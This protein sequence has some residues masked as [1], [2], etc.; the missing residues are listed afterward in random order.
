MSD[1][2]I[3]IRQSRRIEGIL[4]KQFGAI[5]KGLHVKLSSIESQVPQHIVKTTRWIATM[6]NSVVH[7]DGFEINNIDSF[8]DACERVIN[9]LDEHSTKPN[10][11]DNKNKYQAPVVPNQTYGV[12]LLVLELYITQYITKFFSTF[13]AEKYI[14][15][16]VFF[17]MVFASFN[18]FFGR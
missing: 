14:F 12:G 7:E 9:Y 3:V 2:E 6:R 11:L 15:L 18:A 8:V 10:T 4:E 1:I 16:L 13:N 5:G 17:I